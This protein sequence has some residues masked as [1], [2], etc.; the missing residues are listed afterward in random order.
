MDM[1]IT[2]PGGLNRWLV[3]VRTMDTAT[4]RGGALGG[5]SLDRPFRDAAEE[6]RKRYGDLVWPWVITRLG[7][8]GPQAIQLLEALA[9]DLHQADP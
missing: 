8:L 1:V 3:D 4:S 5:D 6:K 2:R 7:K 9:Q